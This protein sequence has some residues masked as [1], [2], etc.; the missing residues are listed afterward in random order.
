MGIGDNTFIFDEIMND[1]NQ[2]QVYDDLVKPFVDKV[3][4]GFDCTVLAYGQ[5]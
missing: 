4:D 2:K 1:W 3:V 5:T